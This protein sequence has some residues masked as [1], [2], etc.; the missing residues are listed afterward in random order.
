MRTSLPG[1]SRARQVGHAS[2]ASV[3]SREGDRRRPDR[4]RPGLLSARRPALA[5][6]ADSQSG[7]SHSAGHVRVRREV[8]RADR[9][10]G[11]QRPS[12]RR[13]DKSP[14]HRRAGDQQPGLPA[15]Y[16]EASTRTFTGIA[17]VIRSTGT[18]TEPYT[19]DV[20]DCGEPGTADTFGI[21]TTTY[22]NGP[23]T[24]IGGTSR[25]SSQIEGE[26]GDILRLAMDPPC[27]RGGFSG[28]GRPFW[29]IAVQAS[30]ELSRRRG[31]SESS[32]ARAARDR[33]VTA[34]R[35]RAAARRHL[36]ALPAI[37]SGDA[38]GTALAVRGTS[39]WA[40]PSAGAP[41]RLR[42][43]PF[44]ALSVHQRA[45]NASKRRHRAK[46]QKS[47]DSTSDEQRSGNVQ[48]TAAKS[49]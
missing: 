18:T 11:V 21:K 14:I 31:H 4:E 9:E 7:Q 39:L 40:L 28:G 25:S 43:C 37:A 47:S 10:P 24:L 5:A 3:H 17:A 19:V 12:G 6:G 26:A 13:T 16:L 23:S 38:A 44:L 32:E 30:I 29:F 27:G 42:R 41:Q 2:A 36:Y 33:T 46:V 45:A 15:R 1:S 20:D 22:A 48:H 34:H 35:R 8:L 49:G